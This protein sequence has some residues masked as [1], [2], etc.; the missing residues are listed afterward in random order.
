MVLP[1]SRWPSVVPR[2]LLAAAT[3]PASLATV[4]AVMVEIGLLMSV[5]RLTVL[6]AYLNVL[7]RVL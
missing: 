6:S 1:L 5:D 2:G 7:T 4:W 3:T